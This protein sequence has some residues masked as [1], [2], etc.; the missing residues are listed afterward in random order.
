MDQM[1]NQDETDVDCGG[2][3]CPKCEASASCQDK[4]KN[5]DE[6]DIDCGGS[7]CQKCEDSKMCKDNCDCVGGICTSNKICS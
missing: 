6:T 1:K 4:I 5:Q 7:K 2:I 3:S